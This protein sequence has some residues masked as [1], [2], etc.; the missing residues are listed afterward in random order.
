ML[1]SRKK[2][3]TNIVVPLVQEAAS[4][5]ELLSQKFN[6]SSN[7]YIFKRTLG[8]DFDVL[9]SRLND[10]ANEQFSGFS[11]KITH[12]FTIEKFV[13]HVHREGRGGASA[14][15]RAANIVRDDF[16]DVAE[17]GY[18]VQLRLG[19]KGMQRECDQAYRSESVAGT[20]EK[21]VI[22]YNKPMSYITAKD[23]EASLS[24]GIVAEIKKGAIAGVLESEAIIRFA[25]DGAPDTKPFIFRDPQPLGQI[26]MQLVAYPKFDK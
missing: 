5:T 19:T 4:F 18:I 14:L 13:E 23:V 15:A 17:R 25:C 2:K 11:G 24:N 6:N 3:V 22:N 1:E 20:S 21:I 10:F 9:A 7:C 8:A 26:A 12:H 16:I